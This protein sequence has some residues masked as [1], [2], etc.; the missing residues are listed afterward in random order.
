MALAERGY[1]QLATLGGPVT[2]ALL[3]VQAWADGDL[4]LGS[5]L[6]EVKVTKNPL[7]LR[8]A[9]LDQLLGYTLLDR[10]DWYGLEQVAVFLGRQARLVAWPLAEL[11]PA[12][13][14]DPQVTLAELRAEFHGLLERIWADNPQFP[15][16]HL[17]VTR[18]S[19]P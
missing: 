12:L 14:G 4:V 3:F 11:L 10:G 2:V 15:F 17:W 19:P 18:T 7:P 8:D 5:T 9:W 1:D 6:V 13:T 16:H